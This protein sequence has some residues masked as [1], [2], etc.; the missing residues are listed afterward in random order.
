MKTFFASL[1]LLISIPVNAHGNNSVYS[2]KKAYESQKG[3]ALETN[4]SDMNIENI[5]R[6]TIIHKLCKSSKEKSQL[7]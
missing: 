1:L 2:N 7:L 3:Y 4:V 6:E 5:V